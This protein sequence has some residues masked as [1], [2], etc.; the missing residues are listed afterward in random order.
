MLY[1]HN[2]EQYIVVYSL[3]ATTEKPVTSNFLHSTITTKAETSS[4]P[5]NN[6]QSQDIKLLHRCFTIGVINLCSG[7]ARFMVM[8]NSGDPRRLFTFQ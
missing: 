8:S 3:T 5:A 1:Q 6:S 7:T 2:Y 4:P